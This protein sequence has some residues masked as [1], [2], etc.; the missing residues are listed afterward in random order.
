MQE[1]EATSQLMYN[2]FFQ[3]TIQLIFHILRRGRMAP[4]QHPNYLYGTSCRRH[5]DHPPHRVPS[6]ISLIVCL[7]ACLLPE[8]FRAIELSRNPQIFLERLHLLS[9]EA[10][11]NRF[12]R[13]LHRRR[14][15]EGLMTPIAP[16]SWK[17]WT[18]DNNDV[19]ANTIS[20]ADPPR[21]CRRIWRRDSD[22]PQSN[23]LD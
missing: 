3:K 14:H 19:F 2:L 23:E 10:L 21:G 5:I 18:M 22:L 17:V 8:S 1:R 13:K 11:T 15:R 4:Q 20:Q 16:I 6:S 9:I 12:K 7:P